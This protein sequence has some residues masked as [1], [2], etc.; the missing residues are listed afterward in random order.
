V[1][2]VE[3]VDDTTCR[4]V[5]GGNSLEAL[6]WHFGSLGHPF[7]IEA[8]VELREATAAFGARLVAAA[9]AAGP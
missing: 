3:S 7:S 8:P 2:T 6:A 4:V 1:G 5:A 9:V